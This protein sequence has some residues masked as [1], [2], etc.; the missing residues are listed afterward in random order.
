MVEL[1]S[2][3]HR[4]GP[5]HAS[6]LSGQMPC[7]GQLSPVQRALAEH[8]HELVC[9]ARCTEEP[10]QS[11]SRQLWQLR[12]IACR[13]PD[14]L[15]KQSLRDSSGRIFATTLDRNRHDAHRVLQQLPGHPVRCS[16]RN[17]VAGWAATNSTC[18]PLSDT[19][20]RPFSCAPAWQQWTSSTPR[21]GQSA[22][23]W[24]RPVASAAAATMSPTR[25]SLQQTSPTARDR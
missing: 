16:D 6:C 14:E 1:A 2:G 12:E 25:T 22:L 7:T 17:L 19:V 13:V 9:A 24:R 18:P 23:T 15:R 20:W 5:N 3:T 21:A 8:K 10:A 4:C 11:L